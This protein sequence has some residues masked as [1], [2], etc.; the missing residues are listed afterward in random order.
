MVDLLISVV[1]T[2][3]IIQFILGLLMAFNVVSPR[4]DV[5]QTIY[6]SLNALL[7]PVLGPI[8]RAMPATGAIDFSPLVLIVGLQLLSLLLRGLAMSGF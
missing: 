3:V 8:R 6:R 2:I 5:V 7:E 4:N 1:T